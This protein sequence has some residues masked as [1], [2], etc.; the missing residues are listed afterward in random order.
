MLNSLGQQVKGQI[1]QST[2]GSDLIVD[3]RLQGLH[4]VN[5]DNALTVNFNSTGQTEHRWSNA[6][7]TV[8]AVTVNLPLVTVPGQ[9]VTYSNKSVVTALTVVP[10]GNSGALASGTLPTALTA[11]QA[12]SFRAVDDAGT[13]IRVS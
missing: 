9:T 6:G 1:A 2:D 13:F 8:A 12:V 4:L 7:S 11:G 5:L 10:L 3:S